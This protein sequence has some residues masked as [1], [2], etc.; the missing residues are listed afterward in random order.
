MTFLGSL[1]LIIFTKMVTFATNALY[2][3]SAIENLMDEMIGR[4]NI[5]QALSDELIITAYEFN[6]Q[7]A[8]LYSKY[9]AA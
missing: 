5:S 3:R 2:D 1:F 6:S 4:R 9:L 7:D 8:R